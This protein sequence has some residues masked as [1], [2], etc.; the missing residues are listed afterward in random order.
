MQ[1]TRKD[2][3]LDLSKYIDKQIRVKF[4]GGREGLDYLPIV[5]LLVARN[6]QLCLAVVGVLKGFDPLMNLVLDESAEVASEGP[7]D[8]R[9]LGLLVARGTNVTSICPEDEMIEIE[10]PFLAGDE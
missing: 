8:R 4:Q 6:H 5:Y 9:A 3:V 10:N 1:N 2:N 7:A